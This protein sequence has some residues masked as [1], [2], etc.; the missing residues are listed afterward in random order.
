LRVDLDPSVAVRAGATAWGNHPSSFPW[1]G[2]LRALWLTPRS[3]SSCSLK[4][5]FGLV[6]AEWTSK[7]SRKAASVCIIKHVGPLDTWGAHLANYLQARFC[8]RLF[9]KLLRVFFWRW[10][11][12]ASTLAPVTHRVTLEALTLR[13][14]DVHATVRACPISPPHLTTPTAGATTGNKAPGRPVSCTSPK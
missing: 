3:A 5:S 7:E 9:P 14:E 4:E 6:Q 12:V 13:S 1:N 2:P 8:S 11:C 10:Q